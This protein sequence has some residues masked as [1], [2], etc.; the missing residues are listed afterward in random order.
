M[1]LSK[2]LVVHYKSYM[3]FVYRLKECS[4]ITKG[5]PKWPFVSVTSEL[6]ERVYVRVRSDDYVEEEVGVQEVFVT[7]EL[8]NFV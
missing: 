6:G 2:H 8:F 7:V 3:V 4:T 1:R 5:V